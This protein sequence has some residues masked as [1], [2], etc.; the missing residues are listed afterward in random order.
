MIKDS[1]GNNHMHIIALHAKNEAVFIEIIDQLKEL[2][3]EGTKFFHKEHHKNNQGFTA[4]DIAKIRFQ[5][6]SP[7]L[8]N[9]ILYLAN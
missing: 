7:N 3:V 2:D 6:P 4:Y 9:A 5:S 8:K 1:N